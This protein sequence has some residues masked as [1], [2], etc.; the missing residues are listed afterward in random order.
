MKK[1]ILFILS[2]IMIVSFSMAQPVND[3]KANSIVL[4][5]LDNWCSTDGQFTTMNATP[6]ENAGSCWVNGPNYNVWFSFQATTSEIKIQVNTGSVQRN[7]QYLQTAL[8]DDTGNEMACAVYT[9]YH[10]DLII[11]SH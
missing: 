9:Y 3:N 11:S 1:S 7:A 10:S 5:D 6:D 2:G 8:W 4:S